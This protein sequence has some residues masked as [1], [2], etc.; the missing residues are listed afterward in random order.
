MDHDGPVD[1]GLQHERTALA[2]DRTGL[3]L[4]VVG[5]LMLR[6]GQPPYDDLRHLPGWLTIAFGAV[7]LAWAA[8][9][10][11][12][13]EASLRRGGPIVH[14]RLVPVVGWAAVAVSVASVAIVVMSF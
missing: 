13:R 9:G 14:R 2:W 7:L 8:R 4:M 5:A 6:A 10:Y 11:A 12:V 1:P 3:S